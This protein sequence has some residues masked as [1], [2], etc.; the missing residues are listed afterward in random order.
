MSGAAI[1]HAHRTARPEAGTDG[2]GRAVVLRI[3]DRRVELHRDRIAAVTAQVV[4]S[5]VDL[6]LVEAHRQV[7]RRLG[8]GGQETAVV[9]ARLGNRGLALARGIEDPVAAVRETAALRIH[10]GEGGHDRA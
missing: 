10:V 6:H 9:V 5:G 2:P 1:D 4:E 8:S 7:H 3:M